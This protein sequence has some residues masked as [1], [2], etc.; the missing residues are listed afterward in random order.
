MRHLITSIAFTLCLAFSTLHAQTKPFL[1]SPIAD[2]SEFEELSEMEEEFRQIDEQGFRREDSSY[3]NGT[4]FLPFVPDSTK[5]MIYKTRVASRTPFSSNRSRW[6]G[7]SEINDVVSLDSN[8]NDLSLGCSCTLDSNQI[9]IILGYWVFGGTFVE[10]DLDSTS[11]AARF[12]EDA[13]ENYPF[14]YAVTDTNMV[15]RLFLNLTLDTLT[16]LEK[17]RF[18]LNDTISGEIAL[19]TPVYYADAKYKLGIAGGKGEELDQ[20]RWLGRIKFTCL[21]KVKERHW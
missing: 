14:K 18:Q 8:L 7:Y 19:A 11:Y 17:P 10:I 20:L 4:M 3:L 9:R 13:H 16:L 1:I 5:E 6:F 15:N 21:V 12:I 2:W